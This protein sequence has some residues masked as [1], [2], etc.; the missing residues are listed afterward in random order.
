MVLLHN[1]KMIGESM[2]VTVYVMGRTGPLAC[3][4]PFAIMSVDEGHLFRFQ[5]YKLPCS[6]S[7]VRIEFSPIGVMSFVLVG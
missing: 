6:N 4:S 3:L 5:A 2:Y 7:I 1:K